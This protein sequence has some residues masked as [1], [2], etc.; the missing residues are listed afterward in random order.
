VEYIDNGNTGIKEVNMSKAQ[1]N[2]EELRRGGVVKLKERDMYSIWV[3]TSCCNLNSRQLEKLADIIERYASAFLLFTT[4]Q[5]PII[6]HVNI[7]DVGKVQHELSK[8]DLELDRCGPRVRNIN[9][10]YDQML[11]NEAVMNAINLAEKLEEFFHN[12]TPHK[13]KIGVSG[14][15]R[16]C[17]ASR[18]LNDISFRGVNTNWKSGYDVYIGGRLG[19]NPFVGIKMAGCLSEEECVKLVQNFFHLLELEGKA[20]ERSADLINRLGID[21]VKED[22]KKDLLKGLINSAIECTTKPKEIQLGKEI[23]KVRATCGEVTAIQLRKLAFIAEKY[24]LGIIHFAIYGAPE[25]PGID[26]K[27]IVKIRPILRT[28]GMDVLD[29]GIGNLQSCF[30]AYCTESLVDPQSLLKQ[31]E[32]KVAEVG[33][34]DLDVNISASGCPNSCG[35]AHLSD[36]GFYGAVK[37]AVETDKCN[38]CGLCLQVCK[39]KAIAIVNNLAVIDFSHCRYCGQCIA[40]CPVNA[41][42]Q[43]RK[44]F[45]ITVGGKHTEDTRIGQTIVNF[46]SEKE[47]LEITEACLT[48]LMK[49]KSKVAEIID[50]IGIETFKKVLN[51]DTG[52]K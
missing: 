35:I 50:G 30:G 10:C 9:V 51:S 47:A 28:V 12:L 20:G 8:V 43:E 15:N 29:N 5:I 2:I 24:G 13:I 34:N 3:K 33:I 39:R 38:G 22:L 14:C 21:K 16:D 7:N 36:I 42:I 31:I 41:I 32:D 23:I 1:T 45:T 4:R 6:P 11:C 52:I 19:V 25:I 26:P 17:I 44:G 48:L 27:D 18:V 49:R 46:A 37:P 40:I